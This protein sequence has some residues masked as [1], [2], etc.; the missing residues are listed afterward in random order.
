MLLEEGMDQ[1]SGGQEDS[2]ICIDCGLNQV[3][4]VMALYVGLEQK[5]EQ[6]ES[7][8]CIASMIISQKHSMGLSFSSLYCLVKQDPKVGFKQYILAYNSFLSICHL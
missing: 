5:T 7:H 2:S 8:S 4:L 6:L 1:A 3:A